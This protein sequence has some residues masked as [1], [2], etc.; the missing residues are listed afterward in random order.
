MKKKFFSAVSGLSAFV[1]TFSACSWPT[2]RTEEPQERPN[3]PT[4]TPKVT[5]TPT[6]TP[7]E[8]AAESPSTE[9]TPSPD[10]TATPSESLSDVV[11]PNPETMPT[12]LVTM[13]SS[14]ATLEGALESPPLPPAAPT[15]EA[16]APTGEYEDGSYAILTDYNS[17][18]GLHTLD[19]VITIE[20]DIVT[21][22]E[23]T[24][25][26]GDKGTNKSQVNFAAAI[27]ELVIG[28]NIDEV[29]AYASVNGSSLT[30]QAFQD[31]IEQVREEAAAVQ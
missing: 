29:E 20:D 24:P 5:Q 23:I 31:A 30:P 3:A 1:L 10:A 19:V 16:A 15:E 17:P 26:T 6:Q 28:K 25:E 18:G 12:P 9:L 2:N 7:E 11:T 14:N 8:T 13:G 21:D 22:I 27:D 4:T